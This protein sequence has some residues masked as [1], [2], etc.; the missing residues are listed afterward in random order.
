M[1]PST[2]NALSLPL[3]GAGG[4]ACDQTGCSSSPFCCCCCTTASGADFRPLLLLLQIRRIILDTCA[5]SNVTGGEV[6][7]WLSAGRGGFGL[8]TKECERASL[9]VQARKL[10]PPQPPPLLLLLPPPPPLLLLGDVRRR[11][12]T[13]PLQP[14]TA[15][16][17][18]GAGDEAPTWHLARQA[19]RECP[20]CLQVLKRKIEFPSFQEKWR[21]VT[22]SVPAK[23]GIFAQTK[24][25]NYLQNALCLKEAEDQGLDQGLFLDEQGRIA[26]GPNMN[27][28]YYTGDRRLLV[29]TFDNCLDGCTAKRIVERVNEILGSTDPMV[30]ENFQRF[31]ELFVGAEY[32]APLTTKEALLKAREIF[33]VGSSIIVRPVVMIDG[34]VGIMAPSTCELCPCPY[35]KLGTAPCT[36][37]V[38]DR[39]DE[40]TSEVYKALWQSIYDDMQPNPFEPR[41]DFLVPIPYSAVTG[42]QGSQYQEAGL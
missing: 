3:F 15:R 8:T 22:S 5:A 25:V 7:F 31:R 14:A 2:T 38:G 23:P 30:R 19:P 10:P 20:P 39:Y 33:L 36:Q 35:T 28:M 6:R 34:K 41:P 12:C 24:S 18:Q 21:V 42:G 13:P 29:P 9:Y 32:I 27:I 1:L 11:H 37:F 17:P 26:E 16:K 40:V 4:D